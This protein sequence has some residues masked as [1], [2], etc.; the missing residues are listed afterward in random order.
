MAQV[1]DYEYIEE[2]STEDA[3]RSLASDTTNWYTEELP[4]VNTFL[5]NAENQVIN[6]PEWEWEWIAGWNTDVSWSSSTTGISWTSGNVNLP[7]WTQVAIS[8]WSVN[9]SSS[10][11]IYLDQSDGNV[12][13]TTTARNAVWENKIML[14]VAFPNSWK[15]VSFQAFGC[16]D[17]NSLVTGSSIANNTI[18]AGNIASGTIT[19]NEIASGTITANEIASNTITASEIH[20]WAVTSSKID[21]WAVTADKI[22]VNE[23]SA[24]VAKLWD[25]YVG[26]ITWTWTWIRIYPY[27]SSTGRV[28]F[29]RNWNSVWYIAWWSANWSGAVVVS[30]DIFWMTSGTMVAW[31]KLKI[32]V[33]TNLY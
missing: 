13:S 22:D 19:A 14:C 2:I 28:E 23:L 5:I 27:S 25:V 29:Y 8:S 9:V 12:Y 17:Q 16:A 26:T 15:K 4:W 24:I 7:D 11:Y 3:L 30:A 32:P 20:S 18:V 10:T 31:G 33:W 6:F 1:I 21:S